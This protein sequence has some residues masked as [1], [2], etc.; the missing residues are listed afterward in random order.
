MNKP[1]VVVLTGAGI[2]AESGIRTFRDAGGLWENH[3]LEEVATP[4]AFQRNPR[5]V[6]RFYNLRRRQLDDPEVAPNAAHHALVKLE[7]ALGEDFLL[8][9]QNV[10]DLHARAGSRRLIAMHGELRKARC[11]GCGAI[12]PAVTDL[13]EHSP[14]DHCPA[15]G[16]LR[17]H[18]VWFGE[19]PLAMAEIEQALAQCT[20]FAAIGT[21]GSVYPAAGFV[22]LA[23]RAGAETVEINLE[24]SDRHS[25][26]DRHC[27]GPAGEQVPR[28]VASVLDGNPEAAG[29]SGTR[30]AP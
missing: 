14:C 11:E 22:E 30:Q 9:T 6:R 26:F 3:R 17:P 19:L 28:W 1:R 7:Q 2:S 10:D 18:I 21:S 20:L 12:Q 16:R 5:L 23:R 25:V 27:I 4:Q 24:P 8:V 15:R 29:T 13:D